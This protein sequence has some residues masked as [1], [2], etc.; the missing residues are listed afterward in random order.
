MGGGTNTG[1]AQFF[2]FCL[3]CLFV[4]PSEQKLGGVHNEWDARCNGGS[5]SFV[6]SQP[7]SKRRLPDKVH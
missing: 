1:K 6:A 4:F 5:S 2:F 3:V 7:A